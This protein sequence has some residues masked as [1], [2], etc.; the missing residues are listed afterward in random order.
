MIGERKKTIIKS[1]WFTKKYPQYVV[2]TFKLPERETVTIT[3]YAPKLFRSL[4]AKYISEQ[5]ILDS[6]IPNDNYAAMTNF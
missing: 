5:A 6:M 4:R 1:F 2:N 3:E